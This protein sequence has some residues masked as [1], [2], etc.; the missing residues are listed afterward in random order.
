MYTFF[1][2]N[3]ANSCETTHHRQL[4][5][6]FPSPCILTVTR[7]HLPFRCFRPLYRKQTG[8]LE[9]DVSH[10]QRAG[11]S[12][13]LA[14]VRGAMDVHLLTSVGGLGLLFL[15]SCGQGV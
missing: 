4:L 7:S 1:Y 10:A 13:F 2:F 9:G 5:A 12:R 14:L 11:P 15:V 3:F 8:P 6:S